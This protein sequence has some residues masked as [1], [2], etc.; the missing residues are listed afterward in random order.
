M[1][2]VHVEELPENEVRV[3]HRPENL[4]VHAHQV[5]EIAQTGGPNLRKTRLL[6][7]GIHGWFRFSCDR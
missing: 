2:T 4:F 1:V 5:L 6:L 3:G 7:S